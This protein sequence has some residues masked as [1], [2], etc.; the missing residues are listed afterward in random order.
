MF[1]DIQKGDLPNNQEAV[2][3]LVTFHIQNNLTS[4]AGL[5]FFEP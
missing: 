5:W 1:T 2:D 4:D 3:I